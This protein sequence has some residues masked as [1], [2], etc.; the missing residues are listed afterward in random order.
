MLMEY[1]G[2]WRG[3]IVVLEGQEGR[4]WIEF[5]VVLRKVVAFFDSAVDDWSR[6]M[7]S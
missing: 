2:G 5:V 3:F 4:G 7:V 6:G 1:G